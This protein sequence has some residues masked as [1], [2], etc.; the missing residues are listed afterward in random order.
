[1]IHLGW[2]PNFAL[3][4]VLQNK[5][6]IVWVSSLLRVHGLVQGA[7]RQNGRDCAVLLTA[8]FM[9]IYSKNLDNSSHVHLQY[10]SSSWIK[11]LSQE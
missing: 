10:C 11:S 9:P 3:D 1:M 6:V 2:Y 5:L 8:W 7:F 4:F